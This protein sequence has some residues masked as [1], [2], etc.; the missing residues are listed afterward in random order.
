MTTTLAADVALTSD[1]LRPRRGPRRGI[2]RVR[3]PRPRGRRRAG[4]RRHQPADAAGRARRLR[5]LT[6]ARRGGRRTARR[7]RRQHPPGRRRSASVR[8]CS[9]GTLPPDGAAEVFRRS[10]PVETP[11]CSPR[12]ERPPPHATAPCAS[13][14]AGRSPAT[15][16]RRP[17]SGSAPASPPANPLQ[18]LAFAPRSEVNAPPDVGRCR[19]ASNGEQ[20]RVGHRPRGSPPA[21]VLVRR[22]T[23]ARGTPVA[24]STVRRPGTVA[25]GRVARRR[26]RRAQRGEPASHQ[27]AG[28]DA[29]L[30]ARRPP[31]HGRSR[32][33]RRAAARGTCRAPRG[34]RP[35]LGPGPGTKADRPGAPGPRL[36][37]R[38]ALHRHCRRGLRHRPPSRRRRSRIP[39]QPVA[40]R[41]S[42]PR[43][44][45]PTHDVQPWTTPPLART[46]AGTDEA[47]PPFVI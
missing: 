43:N 20:Q 32:R 6:S 37:R 13:P 25:G 18:R 5:R 11:P 4:S 30:A 44:G 23:V 16:S 19:P 17:G 7:H 40:A 45:A 26:P 47:H 12:W 28:A 31:R 15:A 42:R 39:H 41:T 9:P 29:R 14:G 38:A 36:P 1:V 27:P 33:R 34:P 10:R 46:L 24:A 8:A 35:L 21:Y 3:P 2:R 22:P